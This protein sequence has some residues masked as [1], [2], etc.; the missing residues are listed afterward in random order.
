M[1]IKLLRYIV[2]ISKSTENNTKSNLKRFVDVANNTLTNGLIVDVRNSN[3]KEKRLFIG[4]DSCVT[5]SFIF[6]KET[7]IINIGNRSFVGGGTF[8]CIDKIEIGNDVLIAWGCTIVDNDSH[9]VKWQNR[10]N[11]VIDWKR[12]LEENK[13]GVYK[14][15]ENVNH[16]P[17][18]IKDKSWIGFNVVIL[19]GVTIG[20]GS[21]I[22]AG[23]VVTK[24]VPDYTVVAGN[25]AKIVKTIK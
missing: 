21:I 15:W 11:D 1:K 9:S 6:E 22:G 25:P 24:N 8:I 17:I 3:S 2:N 18:V 12:G 7:G 4:S 10:I 14:N 23:S 20:Q 5:G 13:T 16:A 19:K